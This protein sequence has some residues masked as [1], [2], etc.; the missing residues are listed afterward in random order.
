MESRVRVVHVADPLQIQVGRLNPKSA[1]N[2]EIGVANAGSNSPKW[3]PG[4]VVPPLISATA[5]VINR[6]GAA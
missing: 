6:T 3:F 1:L 2:F 4:V 5:I